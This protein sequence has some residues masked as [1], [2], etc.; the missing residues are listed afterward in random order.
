MHIKKTLTRRVFLTD[1][2]TMKKFF[3]FSALALIAF[4][5]LAAKEEPVRDTYDYDNL[6]TSVR[7]V[8]APVISDDYILFTAGSSA[9]NV[10]IVFDFENFS[11]IHAFSLR[12][13]FDSEGEQTNSWYFYALKI[14]AKLKRVSYKLI[15]DGLWTVDPTNENTFYDAQNSLTLSYIDVPQTKPDATEISAAGVTK[16]VC[17]SEPGQKIRLAGTF[18]NWDSW[19]YEMTEVAPGRYELSLPLPSGT[20]YYAY[21]TGLKQFIDATNPNKAYSADGRIVSEITVN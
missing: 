2:C 8:Q 16:F 11:K 7:G 9:R 1:N 3:V 20:Y 5:P 6:V 12:R 15:I 4:S 14:P 10:G 17:S 13:T 19:I 18:T 21:F